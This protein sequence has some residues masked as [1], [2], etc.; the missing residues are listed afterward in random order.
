MFTLGGPKMGLKVLQ[1]IGGIKWRT[2]KYQT[3]FQGFG[4]WRDIIEA[5]RSNTQ[6]VI[7]SRKG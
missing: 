4:A 6:N 2:K 5:Q 1:T 7:E 3:V